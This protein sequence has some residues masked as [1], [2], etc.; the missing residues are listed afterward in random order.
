MNDDGVKR[1]CVMVMRH[2]ER[3]DYFD[4]DRGINW[5]ATAERPFDPPLTTGGIGQAKKAGKRVQELLKQFG[6]PS[7]SAAFTSPLKR[8][9]ETISNVLSS[10]SELQREQQ[11]QEDEVPLKIETGALHAVSAALVKCVC[12]AL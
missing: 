6:K 8:C 7:L 2:G 4:K 10:I 5:T 1:G 9:G 3:Q 11:Q 12:L